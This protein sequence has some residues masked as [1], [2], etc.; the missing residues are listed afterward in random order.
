[1]FTWNRLCVAIVVPELPGPMTAAKFVLSSSSSAQSLYP[2]ECTWKSGRREKCIIVPCVKVIFAKSICREWVTF[3]RA[4]SLPCTAFIVLFITAECVTDEVDTLLHGYPFHPAIVANLG[5][6]QACVDSLIH[7]RSLHL[8]SMP[9]LMPRNSREL[10]LIRSIS[11]KAT[12][13]RCMPYCSQITPH[14]CSI[15]CVDFLCIG[16]SMPMNT[17]PRICVVTFRCTNFYRTGCLTRATF[18][19]VFIASTG[20]GKNVVIMSIISRVNSV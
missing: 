7:P 6:I 4:H 3:T 15:D 11:R 10:L 20:V 13:V 12:S 17:S 16:N 2:G 1:M 19:C 5:V 8:T 14:R 9:N 18:L